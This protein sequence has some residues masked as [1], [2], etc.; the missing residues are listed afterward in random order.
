MPPAPFEP[1][2]DAHLGGTVVG[3]VHYR[4]KVEGAWQFALVEAL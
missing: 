4:A 1:Q 3:R 2:V